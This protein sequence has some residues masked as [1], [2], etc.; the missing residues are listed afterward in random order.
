MSW[1]AMPAATRVF[2]NNQEVIMLP[3]SLPLSLPLP[4]PLIISSG[5][6]TGTANRT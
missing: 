6:G 1:I 3:L 4:L 2:K 5:T